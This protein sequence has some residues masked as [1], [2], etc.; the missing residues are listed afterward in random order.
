YEFEDLDDDEAED[1]KVEDVV[2]ELEYEG[3]ARAVLDILEGDQRKD[4]CMH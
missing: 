2:L 1:V 3:L 4:W